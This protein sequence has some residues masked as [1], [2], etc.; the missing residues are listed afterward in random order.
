M[1]LRAQRNEIAGSVF[2]ALRAIDDV[3]RVQ[4]IAAVTKAATPSVPRMNE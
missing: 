3:V 1:V 4:S 2:A